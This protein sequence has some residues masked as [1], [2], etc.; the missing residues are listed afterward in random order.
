M[1]QAEETLRTAVRGL[2][3]P[4]CPLQNSLSLIFYSPVENLVWGP[5]VV[6]T[7]DEQCETA[8]LSSHVTIDWEVLGLLFQ[9][10]HIET[11]FIGV[12]CSDSVDLD[13]IA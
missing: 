13:V 5:A 11:V 10:D 1:S 4:G 3:F 2:N 6:G 12:S 7:G 8:F 9:L